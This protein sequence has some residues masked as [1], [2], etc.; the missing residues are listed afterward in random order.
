MRWY[1]TVCSDDFA[2]SRIYHHHVEMNVGRGYARNGM[3]TRSFG[4]NTDLIVPFAGGSVKIEENIAKR[5]DGRRP[6]TS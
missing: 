6:Q 5:N 3:R 2:T 4:M 1:R